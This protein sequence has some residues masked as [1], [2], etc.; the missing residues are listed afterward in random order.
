MGLNSKIEWTDHTWNPWL[1]CT[2]VS[3]GCDHCYARYRWK[4]LGIEPGQ[5]RLSKTKFNAPVQKSRDGS[6]KME[7]GSSVFVCSLSDFWHESVPATDRIMAHEL[8]CMRPD[9]TFIIVTKRPEK[10]HDY[11]RRW[12]PPTE[13]MVF[14][15]TC[16][17][18]A[19]ADERIPELL[20]FKMEYPYIKIGVSIEPMLSPIDISPY[21]GSVHEDTIG[22]KNAD[23]SIPDA[24]GIPFQYPWLFGLDWVIVGGESGPGA[25]PMNPDWVRK[26]RDD[27]AASGTPFFFKQWGAW[28]PDC[29][30][31]DPFQEPCKT[32][33]RPIPGCHGVM[34]RCGKHDAGRLLDGVEH[35]GRIK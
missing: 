8:I 35:N 14:L 33:Q 6:Y 22:I 29:I 12:L 4:Q 26:V 9:L 18:Q 3:P 24:A 28:A 2:P 32:I 17:N 31:G 19:M 16:E 1:G 21:I 11:Y 20:K 34:F 13:N 30:H 7:P 23:Q 15:A 10:M 5:V 25:R 27:C